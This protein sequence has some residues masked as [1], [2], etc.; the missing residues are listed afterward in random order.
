MQLQRALPDKTPNE[1]AKGESGKD[2]YVDEEE[3]MRGKKHAN[4]H[5]W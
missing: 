3:T 2:V 5:K 4:M 1:Q